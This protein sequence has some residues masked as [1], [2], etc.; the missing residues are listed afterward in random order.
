MRKLSV[1][2]ADDD[3]LVLNDLRSMV[4]WE[5]L[6]FHIAATATSGEQALGLVD[7]IQPFLLITDIQMLGGINGLDVIET[8][9]KKY[10]HMKFLVISSYDDFH[11]LKR[12]MASGVIDYLLKTEISP[13][14]LTQKLLEAKDQ[15]SQD[16]RLRIS[17]TSQALE[18]F[19]DGRSSMQGCSSREL[20]EQSPQLAP[21]LDQP[22]YF[23]VCAR[24]LL[25]T[26]SAEETLF[27]ATVETDRLLE[28]IYRHSLN[29]DV[30][31]L[32]GRL[33]PLVVVGLSC[34]LISGFGL[35]DFSSSLS[36]LC[37]GSSVLLQFYLDEGMTLDQFRDYYLPLQPLILYHLFFPS[38]TR[39][40]SRLRAMDLLCYV[41]VT[42]VFPFHALIFDT[43][44]Q[45]QD[46]LLLKS[47]IEACCRSYDIRSLERFFG[48]FCTHL[49][50]RAS[51][52]LLLPE[53]LFAE[54]PEAFQKW[55]YNRLEECIL[56]L[57]SG[58][59]RGYSPKIE[60]AIRFM[61]QHYADPDVSTAEVAAACDLSV[62]RLGTLIKQETGKTINEYLAQI[63]ID[64]AID[65]LEKTNLKIYEIAER[66]GYKSSQYF[67][68]VFFQKTGRKPIDYRKRGQ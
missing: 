20:L 62:S 25:F 17:V 50:L 65:L 3:K 57:K 7:Q 11:Y 40:I 4:D 60:N 24:N 37:G 45:E 26:R 39:R 53:K 67:S 52:Q 48:S 14:S 66:C 30:F 22:Y 27:P 34:N 1:I 64:K 6:G 38:A 23:M 46:I 16:S 54:T 63:R 47:Y 51:G 32:A 8:A 31:P 35:R 59:D 56:L 15:F 42:E 28:E 68:Q 58:V 9:H 43:D 33:G 13:M 41:P 55:I 44:H 19:L 2:I 12:A 29:Y 10:R 61:K 18:Q 21:F 49:E 36:Y 5:A